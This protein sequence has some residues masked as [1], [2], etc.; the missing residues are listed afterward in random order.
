MRRI[1]WF[2][3]TLAVGAL[4][5]RLGVWQLGR[6]AER[7]SANRI[8]AAARALPPLRLPGNAGTSPTAERLAIVEGEYD[9]SRQFVVRGRLVREIPSVL[10]ITPLRF[11]GTDTA[12]LVN[13]GYVPTPDA[14]TPPESSAYS[15]PGMRTVHGVLQSVPDDGD[16]APASRGGRE[17]WHRLDLA[18]M[19][20]RLPYPVFDAYLIAEPESAGTAHT[21]RGRIYPIRAQPPALSNGPHLSYAIQWFGIG[22]A[23]VVFGVVF[24]LRDARPRG[25]K[26]ARKSRPSALAP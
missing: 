3:L 17:T 19:R 20:A 9:E 15:E 8:T 11:P 13:R 7:R 5:V 14:M 2:L 12:L 25:R 4:G 21:A 18:A 1:L 10:V 24:V 6:L 23:A 16:G 22:A 26:E